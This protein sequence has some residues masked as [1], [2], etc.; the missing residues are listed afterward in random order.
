[1]ENIDDLSEAIGGLRADVRNIISTLETE[2]ANA[3]RSRQATRE[4]LAEIKEVQIRG[5][6]RMTAIE[7]RLDEIEPML[8]DHITN[9]QIRQERKIGADLYRKG[10]WG[11]IGT[12]TGAA[13]M[14]IG[15]FVINAVKAGL[16]M[17]A[18]H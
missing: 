4:S 10:V 7:T 16:V 9:C 6:G 11:L 8:N 18:A 15:N 13:L 5:D 1:M 2:R 14:W 3:S 17:I 12:A